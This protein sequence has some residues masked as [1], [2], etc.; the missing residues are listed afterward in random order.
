VDGAKTRVAIVGAGAIGCLFGALLENS[1]VE[2]C[3]ISRRAEV[4]AKINRKGI[5][6]R[7]ESIDSGGT[8]H[9][10]VGAF[11]PVDAA[12]AGPFDVVL[13][14][15]KSMDAEWAVQLAETLCDES[16]IV[17]S[18]QN[19]LRSAELIEEIGAGVP[20]TTYQGAAYENDAEV[21]WT[22]RGSTMFAPRDDLH[23]RTERLVRAI[24]TTLL[25]ISIV[26]DRDAMVWEKLVG[27]I[28]NCVSG[29]LLQPVSAVVQSESAWE[30]MERAR[31]EIFVVASAIGVAVDRQGLEHALAPRPRT[32]RGTPGSTFQS[33]STGRP[34]EIDDISGAVVEVA[35]RVGLSV[36]YNEVL[37]LLVRA[38]EELAQSNQI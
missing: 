1:A 32:R 36:P 4:V 25:P 37:A 2:T 38:R 30:I 19:G 9:V 28:T 31:E 13:L 6:V 21:T 23:P 16:G 34:T 11:E 20:G 5:T 14:V 10:S 18:L 12:S 33:L 15:N 22:V 35:A 8:W 29:A 24:S 26:P 3:I 17:V 27:A 7:D